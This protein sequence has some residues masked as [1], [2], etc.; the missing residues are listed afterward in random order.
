[1]WTIGITISV[2]R[3][4]NPV[5][6]LFKIS[7]PR[8]LK[9]AYPSNHLQRRF[10]STFPLFLAKRLLRLDKYLFKSS[11]IKAVAHQTSDGHRERQERSH[12][13]AQG[14]QRVRLDAQSPKFP[15]NGPLFHVPESGFCY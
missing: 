1:M 8:F 3:P 2:S 4:H 12:N 6:P 15:A 7:T 13:K 14:A 11:F 9:P 5:F 10:P